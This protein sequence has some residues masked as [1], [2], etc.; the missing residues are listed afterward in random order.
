MG[1]KCCKVSGNKCGPNIDDKL[2]EPSDF[3]PYDPSQEPIFPPELKLNGE[4][5][6]QYLVF[7]GDNQTTW[8][9]PTSLEKLLEIKKLHTNAKIVVGNTEIGVEVKFKHFEYP[10][11][12]N[13]SLVEELCSVDVLEDGIKIGASVALTDLQMKLEEQ[14]KVLPVSETKVYKEIVKMLHYFAGRQIRNVASLAGNIMTGSPISDLN[15]ILMAA[16]VESVIK[17]IT[18]AIASFTYTFSPLQI[19]GSEHRKRT[20]QNQNGRKLFHGL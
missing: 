15:P 6:K 8:F 9:R 10:I 4:Y 5:D 12:I 14:I 7:R 20:T 13:S 2:F 17:L 1:D 3:T 19:R 16:K 11:L 18:F